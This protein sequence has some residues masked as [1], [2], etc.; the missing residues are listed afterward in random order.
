VTCPCCGH[1]KNEH[2][3]GEWWGP[4][5]CQRCPCLND[6]DLSGWHHDLPADMQARRDDC[7]AE[8]QGE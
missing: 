4:P 5:G 7:R 2:V 6:P 8:G 3:W 1:A